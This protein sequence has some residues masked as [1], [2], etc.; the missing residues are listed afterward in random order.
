MSGRSLYDESKE[1]LKFL[2]KQIVQVG[3]S[4][5]GVLLLTGGKP[6]PLILGS[7]VLGGISFITY[8]E[9]KRRDNE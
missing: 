7:S 8:S 2:V 1:D 3:I 4:L 6:S 9:I 5:I